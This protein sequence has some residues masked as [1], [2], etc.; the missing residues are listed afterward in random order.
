MT[1]KVLR[2]FG[3][4]AILSGQPP[5]DTKEHP[6][7]PKLWTNPG[8]GG[9]APICVLGHLGTPPKIFKLPFLDRLWSTKVRL[10]P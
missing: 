1:P 6:A 10:G 9:P 4:P 3:L 7:A 8:G 2:F 5:G